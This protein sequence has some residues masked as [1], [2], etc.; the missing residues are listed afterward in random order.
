MEP[1]LTSIKRL[2]AASNNRC[3]FPD[4]DV[5][6]V[7]ETGTVIGIVCHIK[8][9]S[10]GGPRYDSKQ[11]DEERHAFENLILLCPRHSK[12]I[13]SEP[14]TFRVDVLMDM[15]EMHERSGSIDLRPG[16][17][18][19]AEKILA[20]YRKCYTINAGGHVMIDSPG[21]IQAQNVTIKTEKR[22]IRV[23]PPAGTIASDRQRLNYIKHL[24]DRYNDFAMKQP[25][26][27]FSHAAI[28]ADI[29]KRF[30]AKWDFISIERF[31]DL[32]SFLHAKIHRTMLG[33][34]NRGKG[35]PNFSTFDQFVIEYDRGRESAA[36]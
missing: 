18:A 34:I 20:E 27:K 10:K 14:R 35:Y 31:E 28:Y 22:K 9:R 7:E 32:T 33:G 6:I 24:I 2:F 11:T 4:C 13:D 36:R 19:K 12:R 26:R 21:G 1:S 17:S 23:Q 3:A 8:A 15:K 29:K 25:K 30:G 5:P 16:D